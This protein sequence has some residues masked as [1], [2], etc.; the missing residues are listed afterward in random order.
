MSIICLHR[1]PKTRPVKAR[2]RCFC[3]T[4]FEALLTNV[5]QGKTKSCG[6]LRRSMAIARMQENAEAFG[7]GNEKHGLY[8]PYTYQSWNMMVQRCTNPK[9]SNYPDYGGRGIT[10]CDRW[11]H[12]YADFFVDMGKRPEGSTIDRIDNNGPYSPGNC[13]WASRQEQASNRRK[14]GPNHTSKQ[15]GA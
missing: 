13:R 2:F 8:D 11:L 12:S 7:R 9:R 4:E 5:Q 1:I 3:G 10:V 6:C 14:R 15:L